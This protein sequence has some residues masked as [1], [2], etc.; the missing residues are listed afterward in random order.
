MQKNKTILEK[1]KEF[2][3]QREVNITVYHY[4]PDHLADFIEKL[5]S[6]ERKQW[7]KELREKIED[8]PFVEIKTDGIMKGTWIDKKDILSLLESKEENY[9]YITANGFG[10]DDKIHDE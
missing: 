8:L 4:F 3:H 10:E 5:I 1:V 6:Q 2:L 9:P 7:E